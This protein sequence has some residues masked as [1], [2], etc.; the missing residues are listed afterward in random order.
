MFALKTFAYHLVPYPAEEFGDS[1][2]RSSDT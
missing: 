2:A 1:N